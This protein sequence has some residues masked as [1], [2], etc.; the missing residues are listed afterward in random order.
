MH[1]QSFYVLLF[2]GTSNQ[3]LRLSRF[4]SY[5]DSK[6][7][8]SELVTQ[9]SKLFFCELFIGWRVPVS[10]GRFSNM[11]Y[12]ILERWAG[13]SRAEPF[14]WECRLWWMWGISRE[15]IRRVC[16]FWSFWH[17]MCF[18]FLHDMYQFELGLE[19]SPMAILVATILFW[20]FVLSGILLYSFELVSL[21]FRCNNHD[22]L[23][24]RARRVSRNFH[25][26]DDQKKFSS[27]WL[28]PLLCRSFWFSVWWQFVVAWSGHFS[29]AWISS[30]GGKQVEDTL[31]NL[32]LCSIISY[33][34]PQ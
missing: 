10:F 20:N 34:T 22:T 13:W 7:L 3:L 31:V 8:R 4:Q 14:R 9:G 26:F 18:H 16:F 11:D 30:L 2:F 24:M 29:T 6:I 15:H 17:F 19:R 21:N 25:L 32:I 1:V 28:F 23:C 12:Y 27:S 33:G 5:L